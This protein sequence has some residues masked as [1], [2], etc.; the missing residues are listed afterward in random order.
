MA[1][2]YGEDIFDVTLAF[3]RAVNDELSNLQE[4]EN[5]Q[6][7]ANKPEEI[8]KENMAGL[9]DYIMVGVVSPANAP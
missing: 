5:C 9:C 6:T 1:V 3:I 4:Y 8:S 7:R 2:E